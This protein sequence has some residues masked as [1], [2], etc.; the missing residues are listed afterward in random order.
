MATG[1]FEYYSNSK[2]N[3]KGIL[4]TYLKHHHDYFQYDQFEGSFELLPAITGINFTQLVAED[5]IYKSYNL[6]SKALWP[7]RFDSKFLARLNDYNLGQ[8]FY[9]LGFVYYLACG[10]FHSKVGG[11]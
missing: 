7:I 9:V 3:Y 10:Y 6:F 1:K 4:K 8:I 11:Q 2:D 5:L